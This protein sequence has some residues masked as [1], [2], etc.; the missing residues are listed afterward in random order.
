MRILNERKKASF[1][2]VCY[3]SPL[4]KKGNESAYAKHVSVMDDDFPCFPTQIRM[5][6]PP[7]YTSLNVQLPQPHSG[8]CGRDHANKHVNLASGNLG[9]KTSGFGKVK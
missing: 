9:E 8:L 1:F 4:L 7:A 6:H 2:S 3:F 5:L